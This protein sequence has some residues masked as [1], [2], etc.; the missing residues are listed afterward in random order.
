MRPEFFLLFIYCSLYLELSDKTSLRALNTSP[1]RKCFSLLR[2]EAHVPA[3]NASTAQ[4]RQSRQNSGLGLSHFSGENLQKKKN[5]PSSLGRES[6]WVSQPVRSPNGS[7]NALPAVSRFHAA[8]WVR[9]RSKKEQFKMFE[10]FLPYH[11]RLQDTL[12]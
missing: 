8:Q 7:K 12:F 6:A 5:V 2:C 3:A 1:P 11:S 4:T 9:L 10:G